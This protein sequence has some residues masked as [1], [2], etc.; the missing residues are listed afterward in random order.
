M[1]SHANNRHL[2][3]P[4][5]GCQK[6]GGYGDSEQRAD[7]TLLQPVPI[8]ADAKKPPAPAIIAK[9]SSLT[10]ATSTAAPYDKS[11]T[12]RQ[13]LKQSGLQEFLDMPG[14]TD[15]RVNQPGTVIVETSA[16]WKAFPKP[17]C[18]LRVLRELANA[19]VIYSGSGGAIDKTSPVKSVRLP[20]GQR[21]QISVPPACQPDTVAMVFRIA[22]GQRFSIDNYVDSGRLQK[23][24]DVAV[25]KDVPADVHL[26]E[27][28]LEL[29]AAKNAKDMKR[30]FQLCIKHKLNICI[31]GGTG[32]GKTTFMKALA[33]LVGPNVCIIT[34][35]DT[36]ELDLPLHWNKVHLFYVDGVVTA[37][38]Q[39]KNCMRMKPD[40]IFLTELRGNEAFDY[41]A[42]LNTGHPGSLTTV[43]ADNAKG[44]LKRIATLLKGSESGGSL[45]WAH[46]MREVTGSIDVVAQ[47][48][49]T[50]M[51]E[52][53]FDPVRKEKML[54]G[55]RDV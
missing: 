17:Q 26:A 54:R 14:V 31:A 4:D 6:Q 49:N 1:N 45:D 30:F 44:A 41:I 27:H 22:S 7:I 34:I 53:Y 33:D 20:D 50:H 13:L 32:S 35:E 3:I 51:T 39:L 21:G 16:G 9:P 52:L 37:K 5:S 38:E 2:A 28:E 15:V 23:F 10:K 48:V 29:L 36:H 24:A 46:L 19:A 43:H 12:V 8:F 55:D 11:I 25:F 42:A 18:D 47:F 40:R